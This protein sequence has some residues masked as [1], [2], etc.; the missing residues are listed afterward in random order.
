MQVGLH[1]LGIG[2]GADPAV[3]RAV[4]SAADAAGFSTLWS[5][6]HVVMVDHHDS[7]YPYADDGKIAVPS[8]ADWLD[9]LPPW[10]SWPH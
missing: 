7:P 2:S 4:A 5:G 8:D 3:I 6:E 1:A 9:P 10:R